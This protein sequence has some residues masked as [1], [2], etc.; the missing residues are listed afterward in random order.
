MKIEP[1]ISEDILFRR[2]SHLTSMPDGQLITFPETIAEL[3]QIFVT[4]KN[5]FD[6]RFSDA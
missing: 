1:N 4:E 6:I 2:I 3:E 5:K